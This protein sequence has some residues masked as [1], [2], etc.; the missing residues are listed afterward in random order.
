LGGISPPPAIS[1]Y[2]TPDGVKGQ[3]LF[4]FFSNLLKFAAVI[5]GLALIIQIIMAGYGFIMANGDS[6]KM[7]AAWDKIWQSLLGLLIVASAFIL[8][9]LAQRLTGIDPVNPIIYGP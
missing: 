2:I 8:A 5:A 7:T 9:G 1:K 3:G 4:T 6:K